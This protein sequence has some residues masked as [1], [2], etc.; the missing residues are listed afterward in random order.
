[1]KLTA[2]VKLLGT[3]E[4]SAALLTT[5]ETANAA[6][7]LLS[8]WAWDNKTFG[9][10]AIH[11]GQYASVRAKTGLAAQVVVRCISKVADAYKLDKKTKRQFRPHGSI[12]YDERILRWYIDRQTVSIWTVA[13]RLTLSF[14]CGEH[15]RELL[16]SQQGET[17]L[18]YHDGNFYLLATCNVDD[19]PAV[20]VEGVLGVD[21]GIENIAVDSEGNTYTG[22]PIKAKRRRDRQHRAELQK[23]VTKSAKRH[24]VKVRR[25]QRRF[26]R[27]VNHNIS[28]RIVQTALSFRCPAKVYALAIGTPK[29]LP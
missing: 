20:I 29:P 7:N 5:L 14:A 27:W 8:D 25:R 18:V 13:G 11:K 12:A 3:P 15:Q 19:P 9:Q 6:C 2:Q 10:Y 28:K 17:D 4:Q 16:P 21:F 22:E 23:R 1:L 26:V 24:L